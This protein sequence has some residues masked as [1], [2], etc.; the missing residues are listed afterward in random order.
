MSILDRI[1]LARIKAK[2]QTFIFSIG[3]MAVLAGWC[4]IH[5]DDDYHPVQMNQP[6]LHVNVGGMNWKTEEFGCFEGDCV[7]VKIDGYDYIFTMEDG[8]EIHSDKYMIHEPDT[9]EIKKFEKKCEE[10]YKK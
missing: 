7:N 10:Y 1:L 8:K 4:L 2:V 5:F 9:E 3:F 6:K